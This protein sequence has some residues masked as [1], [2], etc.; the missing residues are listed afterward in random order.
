MTMRW[1][2]VEQGR[3]SLALRPNCHIE[4]KGWEAGDISGHWIIGMELS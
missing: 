3:K 1:C 4:G 2:G